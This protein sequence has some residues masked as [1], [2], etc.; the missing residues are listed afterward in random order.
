VKIKKQNQNKEAVLSSAKDSYRFKMNE[1][2]MDMLTRKELMRVHKENVS[3]VI[4]QCTPLPDVSRAENK[5]F[6]KTLQDVT[7]TFIILAE[8]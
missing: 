3:M 5:E 8:V 7:I 2:T 6:E 1:A 4:S